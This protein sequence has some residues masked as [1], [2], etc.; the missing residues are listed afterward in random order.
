MHNMNTCL[1]E[2]DKCTISVQDWM[3]MMII[4]HGG[5]TEWEWWLYYTLVQLNENDDYI[6][7]WYNWM[8]MMIILHAGTTEWEWWLY[9]TVVQL[10]ENDDYITRWYN[11]M[12]MMIILLDLWSENY[13]C[14]ICL[15]TWI[16]LIIE[17]HIWTF[18]LD[19]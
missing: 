19:W 17:S 14:I 9:Y 4:L 10:N 16:G 18:E 13:E 2:K 11:W 15:N 5:T 1:N 3:R 8:R 7:R 6:T 12:R